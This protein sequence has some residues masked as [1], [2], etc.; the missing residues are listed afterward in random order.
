M[1]LTVTLIGTA[2]AEDIKEGVEE[3]KEKEPQ[4]ELGLILIPAAFE[5]EPKRQEF[6]VQL[7]DGT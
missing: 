5:Q 2:G 7:A 1:L 3:I 6:A 4:Y